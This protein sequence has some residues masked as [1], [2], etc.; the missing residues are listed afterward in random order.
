MLEFIIKEF[1]T[2][3]A[4]TNNKVAPNKMIKI[5]NQ[6]IYNSN[7]NRFARNIVMSNMHNYIKSQLMPYKPFIKKSKKQ[8]KSLS[9]HLEINTVINHGSISMRGNK[10]N[11]KKAMGNYVPNW[12]IENL[13]TIWLKALIDSLVQIGLI[14]DDNVKYV[15]KIS[16]EFKEIEMLEDRYFKII[17]N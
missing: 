6:A 8:F 15:K 16:Y 12:D 1:P 5:N 9:I 4:K 3:I 7:L 11:W 14:P 2:H 10:L 17:I 13:A